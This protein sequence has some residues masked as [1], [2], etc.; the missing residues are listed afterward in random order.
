MLGPK[1]HLQVQDTGVVFGFD[2]PD[3]DGRKLCREPA[4]VAMNP[5]LQGFLGG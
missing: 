3:Q 1:R 4:A 5:A 2:I